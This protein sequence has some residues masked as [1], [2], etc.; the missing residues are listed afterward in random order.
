MTSEDPIGPPRDELLDGT[1]EFVRL[2]AKA[3]YQPSNEMVEWIV[4][5]ELELAETCRQ[6]AGV[7]S[8]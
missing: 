2:L 4:A 7:D 3:G 8:L 1:V 5:R 6:W